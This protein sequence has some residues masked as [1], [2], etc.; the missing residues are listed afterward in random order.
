MKWDSPEGSERAQGPTQ[1][2]S[3]VSDAGPVNT[4]ANDPLLWSCPVHH[5][6][7]SSA[8]GLPVL[9]VRGTPSPT[10]S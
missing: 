5:R 8:S 6:A 7:Q 1:V 4:Q 2:G 9:D 10:Q 3:Q